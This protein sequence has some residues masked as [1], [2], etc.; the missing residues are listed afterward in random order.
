MENIRLTGCK[1]I[2]DLGGIKTKIGVVK[3]YKLLRSDALDKLTSEDI[4]ILKEKYKLSTVIDLRTD[5][6]VLERTDVEI[7]GVKNLQIPIFNEKVPGMTHELGNDE[8]DL[9]IDMTVLYK[10]IISFD[11]YLKEL[12]KVIKTI[13]EAKDDEYSILFHCTEGKDRTG[14]TSAILLLILGADRETI[15]EEYMYTNIA[16]REK[17]EE[18][19]RIATS[20]GYSID[21]A[22]QL[23]KIF[24]AKLEYIEPVLDIIDNKWGGIDN[25]VENVLGIEKQSIE[26]FRKKVIEA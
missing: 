10:E 20:R 15:L 7:P 21:R 24:L 16:N 6:E 12:A 23:K 19:F 8:A 14:I 26:N 4:K 3:K 2:R 5:R 9:Q 17:A 22:E 1:N 11:E 25:F 18:Y 13:I